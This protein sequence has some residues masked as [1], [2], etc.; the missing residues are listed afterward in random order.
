MATDR[1]EG[2][3][4][5]AAKRLPAVFVSH[6]A[7]TLAVERNDTATFLKNLGAEL[8]KPKAILC[9]SAH[10]STPA[11]AVSSAERP[12]T[13]HDF[14]GFPEELYRIRYPASGAPAL[15]AH[16]V[17]LLGR[18][19]AHCS[20]VEGRG[21][22]HGAWVPL[23]LLYPEADVPVAQLSIQAASGPEHHFRLGRALAPLRDEGVL[24]LATGSAT[25]NLG[26]LGPPGAPPEWAARFDEWLFE[27]LTEGSADELMNYRGL[28]PYASLAHPTDEHLLPLFVAAGA[29]AEGGDARALCLHRGW[30]FGSLSMAAYSFGQEG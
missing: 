23:R 4:G 2:G 20:V 17:N 29:G 6:G 22:D 24:L 28:A 13:I 26:R 12:E 10:W 1:K 7:P 18:A 5:A 8:G 30:T 25:H 15:A 3:S 21:L 9:V 27:K 14:G 11:P 19:G 16:V